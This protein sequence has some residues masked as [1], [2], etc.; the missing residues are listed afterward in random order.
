MK[1]EIRLVMNLIG[2]YRQVHRLEFIQ[3]AL[4]RQRDLG[5]RQ[6]IARA[7]PAAESESGVRADILAR[8]IERLRV[9]EYRLIEAP[10]SSENEQVGT[11]AE[12]DA[13]ELGVGE[14]P[15][16]R[17][18]LFRHSWGGYY[19]AWNL[20][21]SPCARRSRG[22]HRPGLAKCRLVAGHAAG[23]HV[24]LQRSNHAISCLRR[25]RGRLERHIA[26]ASGRSAR[27]TDGAFGWASTSGK[28]TKT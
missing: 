3:P 27:Y 19:C 5:T 2:R 26:V 20:P 14:H 6:D 28:K 10:R 17:C 22:R 24:D 12:F 7:M 9:G 1:S 23:R 21:A 13:G 4:D 8:K 25:L 16:W 18:R 15:A 11:L